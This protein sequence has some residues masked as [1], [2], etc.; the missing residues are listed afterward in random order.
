MTCKLILTQYENDLCDL[1]DHSKDQ[2]KEITESGDWTIRYLGIGVTEYVCKK[3]GQLR[4][5]LNI[6]EKTLL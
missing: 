2:L 5:Y 4:Q 3:C 6:N 1:C